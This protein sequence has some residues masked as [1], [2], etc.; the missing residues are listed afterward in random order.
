MPSLVRADFLN[1]SFWQLAASSSDNSYL[2]ELITLFTINPGY[3]LAAISYQLALRATNN[4]VSNGGRSPKF[5]LLAGG[6]KQLA[7][8]KNKFFL[9]QLNIVFT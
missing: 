2:I 5:K 1:S 4:Q 9:I 3:R 6:C 7:Y 8:G